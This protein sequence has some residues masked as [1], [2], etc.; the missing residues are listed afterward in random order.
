MR[1]LNAL[2]L[3]LWVIYWFVYSLKSLDCIT[4]IWFTLIALNCVAI[5]DNS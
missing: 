5:N 3:E 1:C 2:G 4:T